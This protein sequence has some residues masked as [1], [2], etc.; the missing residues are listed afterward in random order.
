MEGLE[1]VGSMGKVRLSASAHCVYQDPLR[2]LN[3]RPFGQE[4]IIRGVNG[5]KRASKE[6]RDTQRIATP[7]S[8]G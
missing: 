6:S 7:G 2:A 5:E 8:S 3:Q 1:K 4:T